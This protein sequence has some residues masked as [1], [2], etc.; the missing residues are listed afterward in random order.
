MD[1]ELKIIN[2]LLYTKWDELLLSSKTYSFFHSSVWARVLLESYGYKPLYFAVINENA[3]LVLIP[4]MEVKSL[5]TGKRG[6]SLPFSDYCE[7]IIERNV[8]FKDVLDYVL[9]YGRSRNWKFVEIRGGGNFLQDILPFSC[10]YSHTLRLSQDGDKVFSNF[11]DSTKRNVKK[12]LHKGVE[13][14]IYKSLESI[15]KFY[16]LNCITRKMHGLPPQPYQFFKKIYDFIISRNLGIVVLA[17]NE[18]RAIAGAVFFHFGEKALLKYA[19]SDRA[20]QHLRPNNLVLW[21]GIKWYCENGYKTF[22]FGRT[23][24]ENKGL[25]QYKAGWGTKESTIKYYRFDVRNGNTIINNLRA[26]RIQNR[27]FNKMPIALL[28]F[29]GS[30]SYRHKG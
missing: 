15:N 13:V 11:R 2:P 18:K 14:N 27:V 4:F 5:F 16:K 1:L 28:K 20:Y 17:Y 23:E 19:A 24:M 12:A 26:S 7:P 6:V 25:R 10:F 30:I 9:E 22:C 8:N 29:I 21:K 3:L